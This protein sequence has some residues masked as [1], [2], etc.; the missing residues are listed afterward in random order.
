[1]MTTNELLFDCKFE[2]QAGE[3]KLCLECA[4]EAMSRLR[5]SRC[6]DWIFSPIRRYDLMWCLSSYALFLRE[7]A[8]GR[9]IRYR[10]LTEIAVAGASV[11]GNGEILK[12]LERNGVAIPSVRWGGEKLTPFT[13]AVIGESE[14]LARNL[15]ARHFASLDNDDI[16]RNLKACVA[17]GSSAFVECLLGHVKERLAQ[18]DDCWVDLLST[19]L[20]SAVASDRRETI[21]LIMRLGVDGARAV[22]DGHFPAHCESSLFS[23]AVDN[24]NFEFAD[25][26]LARGWIPTGEDVWELPN[27]ANALEDLDKFKY[28]C[29]S[30]PKEGFATD[31]LDYWAK[32]YQ[33][34]QEVFAYCGGVGRPRQEDASASVEECTDDEILADFELLCEAVNRNPDRLFDFVQMDLPRIQELFAT[35]QANER[36]CFPAYLFRK[37]K[38]L[39]VDL[40]GDK[41]AE[42]KFVESIPVWRADLYRP[43][44]DELGW[45]A[46]CIKEKAETVERE[47]PAEERRYERAAKARGKELDHFLDDPA[48]D[49]NAAPYAN[50]SFAQSVRCW[51][52]PK[53]FR[54]WALRGMDTYG[55]NCEG[56]YAIDGATMPKWRSLVSVFGMSP[57]HV[58]YDGS[59]ALES[60]IASH[61]DETAKWLW[62]H[63]DHAEWQGESPLRLSLLNWNDNL[64]KWFKSQGVRNVDSCGREY[65]IPPWV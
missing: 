33:V 8:A 45:G 2:L 54:A 29:R 23:C 25:L 17:H 6:L 64:A 40:F 49:P 52:T 42:R 65:P 47:V 58:A 41:D 12:M 50:W 43:H 19:A 61:D 21:Q 30:F 39:G 57:M 13:L 55:Q 7:V 9:K 56:N 4:R 44:L 60:A 36:C 34:S 51:G 16:E 1:M 15:L 18:D 27:A 28:L 59:S 5:R 46:Y 32:H 14:E 22:T 10:K 3:R 63:G 62:L 53:T 20:F 31:V 35:S 24:K 26:C 48:F 11:M 38:S 37:A